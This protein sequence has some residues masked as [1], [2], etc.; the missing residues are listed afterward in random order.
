MQSK[1][2]G[3]PS[4]YSRPYAWVHRLRFSHQKKIKRKDVRKSNRRSKRKYKLKS[5]RLSMQPSNFFQRFWDFFFL[6]LATF[7]SPTKRKTT[8]DSQHNYKRSLVNFG[9]P[10]FRQGYKINLCLQCSL[11]L[12][13][14]FAELGGQVRGHGPVLDREY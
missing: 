10:A 4:T 11:I 1:P 5:K 8:I 6:S 3:F 12:T 13:F 14:S 7:F 9:T 2:S